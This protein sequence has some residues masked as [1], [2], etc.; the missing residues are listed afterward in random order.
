MNRGHDIL[1]SFNRAPGGSRV[2][3]RQNA[4]LRAI[5]HRF[6]AGGTDIE[7]QIGTRSAIQ[8]LINIDFDRIGAIM[9]FSAI[10]ILLNTVKIRIIRL[11]ERNGRKCICFF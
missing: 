1:R 8:L 5:Q 2:K 9:V 7:T 6:G 4:V 10:S 11:L 3:A